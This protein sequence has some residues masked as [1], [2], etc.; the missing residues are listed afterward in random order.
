[1]SN[2]WKLILAFIAILLLSAVFKNMDSIMA[3]LGDLVTSGIT[4]FFDAIV[5][6]M[7]GR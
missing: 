4:G 7:M 6:G 5:Y 2:K 3:W 1:M